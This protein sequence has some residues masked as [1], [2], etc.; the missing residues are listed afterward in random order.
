MRPQ[1]L[2]INCVVPVLLLV[3]ISSPQSCRSDD[4]DELTAIEI[5]Q[6]AIDHRQRIKYGH[7]VLDWKEARL[8]RS[9]RPGGG[10]QV[11]KVEL[12]FHLDEKRSD[13]QRGEEL[14]IRCTNATSIGQFAAYV[15]SPRH[16]PF[17]TLTNR[18]QVTD[19]PR[20]FILDP[21]ELGCLPGPYGLTLSRGIDSYLTRPDRSDDKVTAATLDGIPCRL[22]SYTTDTQAHIK[23][24][25][26]PERDFNVLRWESRFT[27]SNG[28][29]YEDISQIEVT[30]HEPSGIW[31]PSKVEYVRK[32]D[33]ADFLLETIAVTLQSL[34]EPLDPALF[35]VAGIDKIAEGTRVVVVGGLAE[36]IVPKT[37]NIESLRRT[38]R[39][40]P[41]SL[42]SPRP[43]A[44]NKTSPSNADPQLPE[45]L[46]ID[47]VPIKAGR[48]M[49]GDLRPARQGQRY[50]SK[51][52]P[53]EVEITKPFE[54]ARREIT[55]KAFRQFVQE[56]DHVTDAEKVPGALEGFDSTKNA[57][58]SNGSF[59][60]RAPG[61]PQTD[62]HPVVWV[63][64]N[65]ALAFC[66]WLTNRTQ[67]RYRL[68]FEAEWEYVCRAGTT[69][70]YSVGD[71]RADLKRVGNFPDQSLK[72]VW[73]ERQTVADWNDRFPFTA[74][75]GSF[76]ANAFGMQDMHGNVWEWCW[77]YRGSYPTSP[78]RNPQ[79]PANGS[80]RIARGSS[81]LSS[82]SYGSA[83][84]NSW[85][86]S[87]A[88]GSIGFRI[89]RED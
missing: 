13:E 59:T 76:E 36:N 40:G 38:G 81:W 53:H 32:R 18:S 1:K 37:I 60:W 51:P 52:R 23:V 47:F 25:I 20:Y 17:V 88:D 15:A 28:T 3:F 69:T 30:R 63:S 83:F 5:E 80:T 65:D 42:P 74:P 54:I 72:A 35:T 45:R 68:P 70:Q 75:V 22:I 46:G 85:T 19:E 66:T 89:V 56:T 73:P 78:Q 58:V 14:Q 57:Q 21:R 61:F 44:G 6:Q 87:R 48:F 29:T 82:L 34:D 26:C 9:G 41:P 27:S 86:P 43:I 8:G 77:D 67:R 11:R 7:V 33:D 79:G 55:V 84:R 64:W 31:F 71:D 39:K 4:F 12:F 50:D 10:T 62:N 24:W 2:A 16:D 49:M